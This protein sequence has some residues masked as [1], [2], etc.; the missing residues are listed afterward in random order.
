MI[1]LRATGLIYRNLHAPRLAPNLSAVA[2][3]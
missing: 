3:R 1:E 2:Q